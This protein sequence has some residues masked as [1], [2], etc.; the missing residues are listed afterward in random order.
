MS[1]DIPQL[2]CRVFLSGLPSW[3]R[4]FLA[5][6]DDGSPMQLA[7]AAQRIWNSRN[8]IQHETTPSCQMSMD[9]SGDHFPERP[10]RSQDVYAYP[11]AEGS[12]QL[13]PEHRYWCE[14]HKSVTH[15][16]SEC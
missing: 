4:N 5:V 14:H 11:V 8:G 10:P 2:I 7:E 6:R 1:L 16:T 9:D 13:V 15:N 12:S 3:L